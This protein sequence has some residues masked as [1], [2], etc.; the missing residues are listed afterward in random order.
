MCCELIPERLRVQAVDVH[1]LTLGGVDVHVPLCI[2]DDGGLGVYAARGTQ[3][4]EE[5][6]RREEKKKWGCVHGCVTGKKRRRKSLFLLF[7]F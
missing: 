6:H 3:H 1:A 7:F 4:E 5:Q 2:A